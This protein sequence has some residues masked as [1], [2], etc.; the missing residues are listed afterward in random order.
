[1]KKIKEIFC[2]AEAWV[3]TWLVRACA[4]LLI[5]GVVFPTALLTPLL[6]VEVGGL[7]LILLENIGAIANW[8]VTMKAGNI[9][10]TAIVGLVIATFRPKGWLQDYLDTTRAKYKEVII[11]IISVLNSGENSEDFKKNI[12]SIIVELED[13]DF[14]SVRRKYELE[15]IGYKELQEIEADLHHKYRNY[16]L[17][18]WEWIDKLF[19]Y[20]YGPSR[21]LVDTLK[22]YLRYKKEPLKTG[23]CL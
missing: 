6:I 17:S 12:S 7:L 15:K 1:M 4:F 11:K 14:A 10:F 19:D 20:T 3:E 13:R 21:E 16:N 5:V 2:N 9:V 8:I 23:C 18:F 22:P